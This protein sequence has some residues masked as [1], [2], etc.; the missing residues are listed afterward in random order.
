MEN[1]D[2]IKPEPCIF[3]AGKITYLRPLLK[4]DIRPEYL[5]WLNNPD[6]TKYSEHFRAWPTTE[7]DLLDFYSNLKSKNHIVLAAC[8]IKSHTHFGNISIDNI[9]WINRNAQLNG[10]I[11]L[12]EYR[13]VHYLEILKLMMNYAFNTLNL[14]KLYNGTEIPG[15]PELHERLGWKKEGVL[16][17]HHF[18]NGKYVDVIQLAI[19]REDFLKLR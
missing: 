6:L 17:E 4:S 15:L 14:N 2:I 5:A 1:I 11:G 18:R 8:D 19:F 3:I 10:M 7:N 16:R 13:V 9:N 12:P